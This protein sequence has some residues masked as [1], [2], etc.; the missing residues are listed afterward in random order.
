MLAGVRLLGHEAEVD[1]RSSTLFSRATLV[2]RARSASLSQNLLG[3]GE[4]VLG[5]FYSIRCPGLFEDFKGCF[6][7]LYSLLEFCHPLFPFAPSMQCET[8]VLLGAGPQKRDAIARPFLEGGTERCDG[9]LEPSG[10]ALPIPRLRERSARDCPGSGP[11]RAGRAR[12]CVPRERHGGLRPPP[13]AEPCRSPVPPGW[14]AQ[15][16][17]SLGAGPVEWD[18]APGPFLEGGME[19][20]D[21]LL[22]ASRAALPFPLYAEQ[23]AQVAE[24]SAE[25]VLGL[26]PIRGGRARG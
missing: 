20:C 15:C 9:L 26:G 23:I 13:R 3:M 5:V 4:I 19:R 25:I 12:G 10:A 18:A 14:R 16:R 22:A 21:H 17:G 1:G 7:R 8:E 6:D 2:C 24:R 11:H